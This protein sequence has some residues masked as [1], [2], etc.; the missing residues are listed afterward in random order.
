[1][2]AWYGGLI[3]L[4]LSQGSVA[5]G[6]AMTTAEYFPLG[7]GNS[8]TYSVTGTQGVFTHSVRVLPGTTI[9]N[10]VATI[11]K[12]HSDGEIE[13]FTND[14]NGIRLH[15]ESDPEITLT[16]VPPIVFARATMN[17][18]ETV[19]STGI[20]MVDYPGFW[21]G[22]LSYDSTTTLEALETVT[23]PAGTYEAVKIYNSTR[24]FGDTPNGRID[25]TDTDTT[26]LTRYIGTVK[27]TSA[28]DEGIDI[29]V[30]ISTNVRAPVP[31]MPFLPILLDLD[32]P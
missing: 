22:T 25:E 29:A 28:D 13:Y 27:S 9:I 23:V 17:I 32:H 10:G 7:N 4:L 15:R 16:M 3:L 12:E 11:A 2:R 30:L 8:W 18:T 6:G 20:I 26:W 14:A 5:L 24:I 21:T 1:M 19:H 31:F